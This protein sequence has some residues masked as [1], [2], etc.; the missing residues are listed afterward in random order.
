MAYAFR[1][2][3]NE[4]IVWLEFEEMMQSKDG[5][6]SIHL[7]GKPVE[8]RRCHSMEAAHSAP[9]RAMG[10]NRP[11]I[12]DSMGVTSNALAAM[13]E[14][15]K[16]HGFK[17]VEFVQ[18]KDSPYFYH[19]KFDSP[20]EW[21]RYRKHLGLTDNNSKNGSSAALSEDL[22]EKAREVAK[23]MDAKE[24]WPSSKN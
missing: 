6:L 16:K 14:D 11:I 4:E 15:R 8:L 3:D 10:I 12:S 18:D 5:F 21:E 23:R 22:L 17:G 7:D 20:A 24:C 2:C 13:E 19:A 9:E 1:R